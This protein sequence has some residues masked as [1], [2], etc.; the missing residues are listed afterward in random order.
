MANFRGQKKRRRGAASTIRWSDELWW[1]FRREGARRRALLIARG[2]VHRH[3]V[4]PVVVRLMPRSACNSC[5]SAWP[6]GMKAEAETAEPVARMAIDGRAAGVRL[7]SINDSPDIVGPSRLSAPPHRLLRFGL[8]SPPRSASPAP[9]SAL[10]HRTC[11]RFQASESYSRS[12][13][14]MPSIRLFLSWN[15]TRIPVF[16]ST[17]LGR[18]S[19]ICND[20]CDS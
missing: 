19:V 6:S 3:Q 11:P 18:A 1:N 16:S 8:P 15:P 10:Q 4:A 2:E 14:F 13:A 17:S 9:S 20:R 7:F 12:L 5:V